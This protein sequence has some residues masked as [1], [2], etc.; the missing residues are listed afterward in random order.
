MAIS[1]HFALVLCSMANKLSTSSGYFKVILCLVIC[2]LQRTL[3]ITKIVCSILVLLAEVESQEKGLCTGTSSPCLF[4]SF[5]PIKVFNVDGPGC[6]MNFTRHPY[7]GLSGLFTFS[8]PSRQKGQVAGSCSIPTGV[9]FPEKYLQ[10]WRCTLVQCSFWQLHKI[11]LHNN[12]VAHTITA[13]FFL[14]G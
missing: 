1:L 9:F 7:L 2:I 6:G 4:F 13:D 5:I 3:S 11:S 10:W 14:R 12:F 8:S